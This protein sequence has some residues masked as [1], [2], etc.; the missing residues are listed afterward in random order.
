[1]RQIGQD[2]TTLPHTMP[3]AVF[4]TVGYMSPEQASGKPTDFRSDQF[5][6]GIILY[7][8]LTGRRPFEKDTA[9]ETMA[10]IIRDE[11]KPLRDLRPDIPRDLDRIVTRCLAK[12]PHDRYASTR[13]LARDLREV[14]NMI[15]APSGPERQSSARPRYASRIK[16]RM[17]PALAIA[18]GVIFAAGIG[19]VAMHR[20]SSAPA[21]TSPANVQSLGVLPFRD[22]SGLRD[23][24]HFADGIAETISS[25]LTQSNSIRVAALTADA[26]GT[27]KEIAALYNVERLLRGSVQRAGDE[28][29]VI[30][31]I[32][33]PVTGEESAGNT[34]T[35][36][37][38]DVFSLEDQVADQVLQSLRVAR[39]PRDHPHVASTGLSRASDQA[40]YLEAVGLLS[41]A[42]DQAA[43]D[44]AIDKL[45]SILPNARDS[46]AVNAQISRALV[47]K[48]AMTRQRNLADEATIYADRAAQNDAR[49][50]E[51][52]LALGNAKLITG[53]ADEAV[54]S[55]NRAIALQPNYAEAYAAL[56][57]A[58]EMLGRA[59]DAEHAYQKTIALRP[60]WPTGF[61]KY[62][63]FCF[64]R[65]R[66]ADAEKYYRRVAQLLPDSARGYTNLGAALQELGRYDE[67]V[68]AHQRAIA[69]A[70][71]ATSYS[72]LGTMQSLLGRYDEAARSLEKA[73]E[74]APNTYQFWINLG[75]AYRWGNRR[76][77]ATKAYERA[78]ETARGALAVNSKEALAIATIASCLAKSGRGD[79]AASQIRSA[80][81]LDP[82]NA[83]VLYEAAVVSQMRG[84]SD[85]AMSWLRRA[86][87]NGLAPHD[88]AADPDL[89]SLR[90]RPDFKTIVN[91]RT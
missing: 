60:D 35:G 30:Y 66:Y 83:Y 51:A 86:V 75:D 73:T 16:R 9:A 47:T 17:K 88:A 50:P 27:P 48:Y 89:R 64:N 57:Q 82:T 40:V 76:D 71:S 72:N 63:T 52:Q 53:K 10:A 56:G 81:T 12:E 19:Y 87:Q 44:A 65:G 34:V 39:D 91:E 11:P 28:V 14:R 58:E 59:A 6:M 80:I 24:Q 46:A 15:T 74:L 77:D 13:D 29:R 4:G 18:A 1:V 55:L 21:A 7:E 79:E 78:M 90:D 41:S 5:A 67:A 45:E 42:K 23:G 70:P 37:V 49:S 3:G 20:A 22:L 54:D 36:N 38:A 84:D 33:D 43:I 62:G 26:K 61:T 85:A 2:E 31:A 69:I 68:A 25:R 32:V 8:L